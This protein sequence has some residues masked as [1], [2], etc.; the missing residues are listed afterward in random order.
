MPFASAVASF[1][2]S[3]SHNAETVLATA[4]MYYRIFQDLDIA[5]VT[6]ADEIPV[7]DVAEKP[8]VLI[9]EIGQRNIERVRPMLNLFFSQLFRE[10]AKYAETQPGCRLAIPL[11]L[12]MDDFAASLGRIPEVGQHLNLSRSRDIRVVAAIQ[13]LSQIDHFYGSEAASIIGGFSTYIFKS[14]VS[15]ADAEWASAHSGTMTYRID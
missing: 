15:Q 10:A 5:S 1:L 12:Y 6:S 8:T 9:L 7:R 14:P 13:S 2:D 3:G 11:N 4:Q